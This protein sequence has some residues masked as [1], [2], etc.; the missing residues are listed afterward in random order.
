MSWAK[1][2]AWEVNF[3]CMGSLRTQERDFPNSG[4][5]F[6]FQET[7][8]QDLREITRSHKQDDGVYVA[9]EEIYI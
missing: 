9:I 1:R 3:Q 5:V 7:E 8:A 6:T 2:K 4:S